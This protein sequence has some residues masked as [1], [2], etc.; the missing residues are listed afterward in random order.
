MEGRFNEED[1][2]FQYHLGGFQGKQNSLCTVTLSVPQGQDLPVLCLD[3][4]AFL[5]E[6]QKSK[7]RSVMSPGNTAISLAR[8][9]AGLFTLSVP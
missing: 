6:A 1:K 9:F 4:A 5:E 3:L 7:I 2:D 8:V